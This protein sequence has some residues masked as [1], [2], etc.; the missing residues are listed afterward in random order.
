MQLDVPQDNLLLIYDHHNWEKQI[1]PMLIELQNKNKSS[2]A[3]L[4][5]LQ[6]FQFYSYTIMNKTDKR[7]VVPSLKCLYRIYQDELIPLY[8]LIAEYV[9]NREKNPPEIPIFK[10]N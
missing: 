1:K 5:D 8:S 2:K 3:I 9:L 4:K 7:D 6:L 10:S